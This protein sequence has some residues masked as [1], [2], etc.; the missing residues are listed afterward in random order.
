MRLI[1]I[2]LVALLS[3]SSLAAPLTIALGEQDWTSQEWDAIVVGAGPAGIIVADKLSE[4]GKKTLLL[5]GGGKSYGIT[6]GSQQP[7]WLAGTN[8]SRVDIPGLYK[9]VFDDPGD[10]T[11]ASEETA[12]FGGCTIGGSSAINA[13]LF[14]QPP[15]SDWD[16]FHPDGWKDA[17]LEAATKRLLSRQK[18]VTNYSA[19]GNFYLQTGYEAAKKW[20]VD[21]A[22]YSNVVINDEPHDKTKVFGRPAYD[23][24]NGQRGGPVTT[25]LQT[26][27]SRSNFLLQ[28]GVR[29]Q[30]VERSGSKATGVVAKFNGTTVTIPLSSTG[31]VV[32][33]GGAIQSPQLLMMSGIGDPATLS[34]LES[35][36]LLPDSMNPSTWINNT[37]VGD[38]LFDNPNTFIELTG[39]SIASYTYSYKSPITSD[40]LM[41]LGSKSGP[42]TFASQTSVFW[43]MMPHTDGTP[44]TGVQGT[45]DSA[46]YGEYVDDRTI[47]LNVYGTSGLL[48]SGRVQVDA[49][50]VAG[51]SDDIY[52]SDAAG[53][54]AS[55]IAQFIH[56]LFQALP[57]S[58]LTPL[59]IP[60]NASKEEIVNYITTPSQYAKGQVNHWSSSCRIGSCVDAEALKVQGTDNV[61]VV[62]ASVVAPLTV[63]PQF[64]I[65]VAAEK[66]GELIAAL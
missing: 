29:V 38:G 19:D 4:A 14:F 28:S 51:P 8:M 52:Y 61:H 66:G 23:Y 39:P 17:D 5:E 25:Y 53:R 22:G 63:N 34:Q 9:S 46:G 64:G 32:L 62:D 10:L 2:P 40:T 3:C 15:S 7:D 54:D 27:L 18:S 59:N 30:R 21:S 57:G 49:K 26:S 43:T 55:D 12:A 47:T 42:Y 48:S 35:N 13:G 45:I 44:P 36:K 56:D 11:C 33:S 60:A 24:N 50:G 20:L 16:T 37:A 6:G 58:G 65:M 1:H 31:R 41:Y